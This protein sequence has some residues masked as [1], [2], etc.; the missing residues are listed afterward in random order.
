[1]GAE[2]TIFDFAGHKL[3]LAKGRLHGPGGEVALRPK[4]FDLLV[5]L[6]QN[7]GR[8]IPKDELLDAIWPDV[9]VTEDSLTQ[10]IRDI[11]LALG[12]SGAGLL[13]TVP[14]RG[15]LFAD[16]AG[17][18]GPAD[19][20]ELPQPNRLGWRHRMSSKLCAPVRWAMV[21]V[22]VA[23]LTG[24]AWRWLGPGAPSISKASIAVLPFDNLGDEATGRLASGITEDIITDL[25]RFREF[26]VIAQNSVRETHGDSATDIR[27][28]GRKFQV[29]YVLNGSIQHQG[30]RVRITSQL[31]DAV[32]G[33]RVW[34]DRWDRPANDLFEVQTELS[35]TVAGKLSGIAG[36]IVAADREAARRKPPSDLNT[37]DLYLLASAAKH[38]ETKEGMA[39]CLS[40]LGRALE[41]DPAF[42][43]AW[44]LL[45]TCHAF[46]MRWTENW[47]ETYGRYLD[48]ERRAVEFDPLDADAHAGLAMAL[49]LGGDLKQGEAE[50]DKAL[51]LNPNSADVLTRFAYWA[52]AFDRREEGAEAAARA[53]RL[54]PNAPPWALRFQSAGLFYGNRYDE[55]IKVR[56][57]VPASM[58]T[59]SDYIELATFFVAAKRLEEAKALATTAVA[60]L[61]GISIEGWTGDP[62]WLEADR[63]Q[64][65]AYMRDAGFPVC[66]SDAE[67]AKGGIEVRIPEC[68][69]NDMA[70][71]K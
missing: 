42:A 27:D 22:A 10:C 49:S 50:F 16:A 7:A 43:R 8:V 63:Q 12:E 48:A 11:R 32:S 70:L 14:R 61:P 26:D 41:I 66:A 54:D 36:T 5:Y 15:Y 33:A 29:R 46:S 3:D 59:D 13:R 67:L 62:G 56:Q 51:S 17:W 57:R 28:I 34:A 39:Q 30:D 21:V 19:A 9:T 40:L 69:A 58:F 65:I 71:G 68:V 18:N 55:A 31:V 64:A 44:A 35:Q 47:K 23:A 6:L 52:L 53:V 4:S 2:Q 24:T 37:Y 45:G 1:M 25:S 38:Q 60:T 20:T